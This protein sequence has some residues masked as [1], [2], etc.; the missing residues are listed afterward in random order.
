MTEK[1][2]K[3]QEKT[4]LTSEE[5]VARFRAIMDEA[6]EETKLYGSQHDW[7]R[8][9]VYRYDNPVKYES[10]Y[11]EDGS[12]KYKPKEFYIPIKIL[13]KKFPEF[14]DDILKIG[15]EQADKYRESLYPKELPPSEL[16]HISLSEE[17][18]K[19]AAYIPE[20]H[21][22]KFY[23]P[24]LQ[25]NSP[26]ELISVIAHEWGHAHQR[27]KL[28][29][30]IE[31]QENYC[32][33][34]KVPDEQFLGNMCE[35]I[36]DELYTSRLETKRANQIKRKDEIDADRGSEPNTFI[37]ELINDTVSDVKSYT[38]DEL[39]KDHPN[40]RTR[41]KALLKKALGDDIYGANGT[42]QEDADGK[43]QFVPNKLAESIN[44][45]RLNFNHDEFK[46]HKNDF[47]SIDGKVVSNADK[48]NSKIEKQAEQLMKRLDSLVESGGELTKAEAA[49]FNK[50]VENMAKQFKTDKNHQP[51]YII[52]QSSSFIKSSPNNSTKI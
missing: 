2:L 44:S 12:D 49:G 25:S 46:K 43:L 8:E 16:K 29:A 42:F 9:A 11:N 10:E 47:V 5:I 30:L 48:L 13:K 52:P 33:R 27:T 14:Y 51:Q 1:K 31:K 20:E 26:D 15:M 36:R 32:D 6:R 17:L 22:I 40:N 7:A 38:F 23:F 39:A 19:N 45:V 41:I 35:K 34:D 21:N 50:F 4:E 37:E 3:D 24:I 28:R 18:V